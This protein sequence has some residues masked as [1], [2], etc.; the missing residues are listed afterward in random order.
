MT[1]DPT[2]RDDDL[3]DGEDDAEESADGLG[4]GVLAGDGAIIG[5]MSPR[6]FAR[7]GVNQIA[8]VRAVRE[9]IADETYA[10]GADDGSRD[11]AAETPATRWA[12]HA[13]NGQRIGMAPSPELAFAA[14]RQHDMEPVSVH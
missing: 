4:L 14:T 13:A 5:D 7:L 8:Y 9:P 10:D 6:D 12:I 3:F 1:D 11:E 2:D